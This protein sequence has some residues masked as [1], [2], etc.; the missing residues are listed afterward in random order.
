MSERKQP[1]SPPGAFMPTSNDSL[2][3]PRGSSV[4]SPSGMPGVTFREQVRSASRVP[5]TSRE[6]L[7]SPIRAPS[8]TQDAEED[9]KW[10]ELF[11]KQEEAFELREDINRRE[12]KKLQAQVSR[13]ESELMVE[14]SRSKQ[15][16]L[17]LETANAARSRSRSRDSSRLPSYADENLVSGRKASDSLTPNFGQLSSGS[18]TSL[19]RLSSI[20]EVVGEQTPK[21]LQ[22]LDQQSR[23]GAALAQAPHLV[24]SAGGPSDASPFNTSTPR[25]EQ[26]EGPRSPPSTTAILSPPPSKNR[27]HAGHTPLKPEA[28]SVASTPGQDTPTARNTQQNLEAPIPEPDV[29]GD[30]PL[31]GQLALPNQPE[32]GGEQ[33]LHALDSKL[34]DAIE[35]HGRPTVLQGVPSEDGGSEAMI[36]EREPLPSTEEDESATLDAGPRLKIKRSLNFGAPIGALPGKQLLDE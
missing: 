17:A 20:S 33:F 13:L 1:K 34:Q 2:Q 10:R 15:L 11:M 26:V 14:K 3:T 24:Q 5:S 16:E 27:A 8:E 19:N 29:A 36:E 18:S 22:W 12:R 23:G 30:R 9:I 21:T 35:G 7:T 25:A 31:S 28:L 6:R 32:A 4:T